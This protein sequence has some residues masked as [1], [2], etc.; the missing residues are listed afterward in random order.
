MYDETNSSLLYHAS[1]R[2]GYV[3]CYL[4][5]SSFSDLSGKFKFISGNLVEE[6]RGVCR[7][8][9]Y[10]GLQQD[11]DGK[12]V[13]YCGN[14][15]GFY[16]KAPENDCGSCD[17]NS[18]CGRVLRNA[19][20]RT[21]AFMASVV[22]CYKDDAQSRD[23]EVTLHGGHTPF[24]C[25]GQCAKYKYFGMQ[26]GGECYCGNAHGRYGKVEDSLCA[27]PCVRDMRLPCGGSL[28]NLVF[29]TTSDIIA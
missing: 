25:A 8:Y 22:G 29:K 1:Q 11:S 2:D 23:L 4:D 17:H 10:F 13:C 24:T 7:A 6:C 28:V 20:Y 9:L 27:M 14:E 26:F 5:S 15:F 3:G 12:V 21:E 19:V 16:G 18:R